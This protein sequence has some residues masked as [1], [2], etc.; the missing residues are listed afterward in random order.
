MRALAT[1]RGEEVAGAAEL[2][3]CR[4]RACATQPHVVRCRVT[5]GAAVA[6]RAAGGA[7]VGAASEA[8]AQRDP[9]DVAVAIDAPVAR[10]AP[11]EKRGDAGGGSPVDTSARGCGELVEIMV[12]M[13]RLH[14]AQTLAQRLASPKA[15]REH[16]PTDAGAARQ[17]ALFGMKLCLGLAMAAANDV[18]ADADVRSGLSQEVVE[19]GQGEVDAAWEALVRSLEAQGRLEGEDTEQRARALSRARARFDASTGLALRQRAALRAP[20]ALVRAAV[21]AADSGSIATADVAPAAALR[22]S[23]SDAGL[24]LNEEE[25]THDLEA[26]RSTS[27]DAGTGNSGRGSASDVGTTANTSGSVDAAPRRARNSEVSTGADF[28]VARTAESMRA[29]MRHASS[30]EAGAELPGDLGGEV[31]LDPDAFLREMRSALGLAGGGPINGD[32]TA[33]AESSAGETDDEY[34]A[35]GELIEE[36]GDAFDREYTRALKAELA[37]AVPVAEDKGAAGDGTASSSADPKRWSANGAG[38]VPGSGDDVGEGRVGRDCDGGGSDAGEPDEDAPLDVDMDVVKNLLA[39][40]A[41]QGGL[42]GPASNLLGAMGITLPDD[43]DVH[44]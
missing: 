3:D 19:P 17:A 42:P 6:L 29:F 1:G 30:G 7:L 4:M 35:D 18:G 25:F 15:W 10:P 31:G 22:E 11:G 43:D 37:A 20:G 40:Y 36:D 44:G 8:L 28:D 26:R 39:S 41:H 38:G 12:P 23:D 24:Y 16:I 9:H 33:G 13:H 2:L 14:Y 21:V 34:D 32:G 5:L 27:A